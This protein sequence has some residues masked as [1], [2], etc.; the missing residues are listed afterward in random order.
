MKLMDPMTS[1]KTYW[2]IV[3]RYLND[4]K[5]PCLTPLFH[6]NKFITDFKEKTELFN[7]FRSSVL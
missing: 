3:K 2:P 5:I 4:K 1:A 7:S 6:D